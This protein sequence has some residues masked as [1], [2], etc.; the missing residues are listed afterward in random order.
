MAAAALSVATFFIKL[1]MV[2]FNL[3][4]TTLR[5][6]RQAAIGVE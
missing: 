4:S 2:G 3:L 6:E 5:A 1:F